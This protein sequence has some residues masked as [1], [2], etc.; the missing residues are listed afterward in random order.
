METQQCNRVRYHVNDIFWNRFCEMPWFLFSDE[1]KGISN[2]AR[3]LY[4]ILRDRH[5][6]S[7]ENQWLNEN[8][9]VYVLFSREEM[10]EILG[11]SE[12]T[13]SRTM[14]VLKEKR[15]VEEDRQ[16]LGKPNRIYLLKE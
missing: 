15:L 9:E 6:L 11:V 1:F 10:C 4:S 7:L 5:E 3:V 2:D 16:G 13:V 14:K 12:N 8:G